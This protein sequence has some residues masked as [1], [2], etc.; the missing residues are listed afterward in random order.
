MEFEDRFIEVRL[1]KHATVK[2]AY[3]ADV[4]TN[5]EA[6]SKICSVLYIAAMNNEDF[7]KALI[8][9]VKSFDD[10]IRPRDI[11]EMGN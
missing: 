6:V 2:N 1:K 5:C 9:V 8:A 4:N 11:Y 7:K 10:P 3:S